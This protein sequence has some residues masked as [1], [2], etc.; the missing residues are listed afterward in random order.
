[1]AASEESAVAVGHPG[2]DLGLGCRPSPDPQHAPPDLDHEAENSLSDELLR[3][4]LKESE[5]AARLQAADSQEGGAQSGIV[6]N[7]GSTDNN[8]TGWEDEKEGERAG[9]VD[10][11]SEER[12]TGTGVGRYNSFPVRPGA[13]DCAF[14]IKTGTC[15]FGS[16]CKFNHPVRRRNPH[17]SAARER[18]N[19]KEELMDKT[20]RIECKYYLRTGGCKYGKACKY[21][22]PRTK[23]SVTPVTELNFLG[24]PI[25]PG[26]KECPYYM[27]N[28][29]CKYAANCR[30]NHPDPTASGAGGG[31]GAGTG[32]DLLGGYGNGSSATLKGLSQPVAS[33]SAPSGT[34]NETAPF[35]PAVYPP[36]GGVAPQK[37]EWSTYQV[38]VYPPE[39]TMLPPQAYMGKN[40]GTEATAYTNN[41]KQMI[42]DEFPERPGQPDCA[43]FLKTGDCKFKSNC[44]YNHPKSRIPSSSPVPLSDKGLPLRPVSVLSISLL[45]LSDLTCCKSCAILPPDWNSS[46]LEER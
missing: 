16:L 30:F 23:P 21:D 36:I 34:L 24:L 1:M 38:P 27:R 41:K 8:N 5:E 39:R 19:V 17:V 11:T 29:S 43:F 14:Y 26:E 32:T 10:D 35:V 20:G 45:G 22:H 40:L 9:E 31:S 13:E 25:R 12:E 3:L 28:G 33:W 37:A 42:N 46:D 15:K 18:V 4:V 6:Y 7:H 44:K 2:D